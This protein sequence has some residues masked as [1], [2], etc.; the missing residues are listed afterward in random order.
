MNKPMIC[1]EGAAKLRLITSPGGA[2]GA[3][4]GREEANCASQMVHV[5]G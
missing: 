1:R 2:L 4:A 3:P 5:L